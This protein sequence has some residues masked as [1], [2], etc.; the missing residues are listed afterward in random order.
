MLLHVLANEENDSTPLVNSEPKGDVEHR[1][2]QH[3]GRR[4]QQHR[5]GDPRLEPGLQRH[6]VGH[7]DHDGRQDRHGRP[8]RSRGKGRE[9]ASDRYDVLRKEECAKGRALT[10]R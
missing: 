1:A 4:A 3:R 10:F 8:R 2:R 6:A 7:R 9:G 5:L